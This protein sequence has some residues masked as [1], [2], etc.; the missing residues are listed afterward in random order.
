MSNIPGD[1]IFFIIVAVV[2]LV[3]FN[4]ILGK[5]DSNPI[6]NNSKKQEKITK[7]KVIELL[8]SQENQL[9]GINS[10]KDANVLEIP[11]AVYGEAVKVTKTVQSGVDEILSVDKSFS[12]EGFIKGSITAFGLIILAYSKGNLSVLKKMLND[13]LFD[14]FKD[15]ISSRNK[16][17]NIDTKVE[18]I[19]KIKI[20]KAKLQGTMAYITVKFI[21]EQTSAV[22]DEDGQVISGDPEQPREITDI[23]TF[24]RDMRSDNPNWT[25]VEA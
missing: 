13:D 23:W 2:L 16:K 7:A 10:N 15:D 19:N 3:Q 5:G 20:S 18:K 22:R 11:K 14:A 24:S 6:D 25:L 8:K 12:L 9:K 21:S 4:S 1:I 17:E